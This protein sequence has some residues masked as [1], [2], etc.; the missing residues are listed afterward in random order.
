[1]YYYAKFDAIYVVQIQRI[2]EIIL[3]QYFMTYKRL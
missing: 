2:R 3:P 1:M